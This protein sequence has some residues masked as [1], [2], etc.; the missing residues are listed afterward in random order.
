[1]DVG[2][3]IGQLVLDALIGADGTTKGLALAGIGAGHFQRHLGRAQL[4]EGEQHSGAVAHTRQQRGRLGGIRDAVQQLGWRGLE[5]QFGKRL[6]GIE[7][8]QAAPAQSRI[9]AHQHPAGLHGGIGHQHHRPLRGQAIGDQGDAAA[10]GLPI[11]A[12]QRGR[13][14][15]AVQRRRQRTRCTS[16]H[17]R[18]PALLLSRARPQQHGLGGQVKRRSQ[19]H[20]A[21]LA[22][23]FLGH[24][25][26]VHGAQA[27]ATAILGQHQR[28]H[29]Q[30]GQAAPHRVGTLNGASL[31]VH[32]LARQP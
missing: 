3:E 30:V 15:H 26:Q 6:G 8:R 10:E 24:H 4:L 29:A 23:N 12:G 25:T 32:E 17:S 2:I 11:E 21:E 20:R 19:G 14:D 27:N 18:Q 22:A 1:M 7:R 13:I 9:K 28:G 31:T 16:G 5:S